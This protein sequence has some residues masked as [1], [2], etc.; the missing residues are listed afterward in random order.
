MARASLPDDLID[1]TLSGWPVSIL[2]ERDL[3]GKAFGIHCCPYTNEKDENAPDE[4]WDACDTIT[5][6]GSPVKLVRKAL[7]L[8]FVPDQPLGI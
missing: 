1:G 8:G 6:D 7:A 4:I 2:V 3:G 5:G